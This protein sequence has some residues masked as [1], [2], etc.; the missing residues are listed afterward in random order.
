MCGDPPCPVVAIAIFSVWARGKAI[1]SFSELNLNDGC[2][3]ST[4]VE[5]TTR[6]IGAKSFTAS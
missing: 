3:A 1:S 2:A 4:C 5:V 6:M